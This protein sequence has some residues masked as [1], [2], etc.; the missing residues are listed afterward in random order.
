MLLHCTRV[1]FKKLN[2]LPLATESEPDWNL[3][4]AHLVRLDRRQCLFF[5]HDLTRYVV[6][7][8]GLRAEH[9]AELGK[10]HRELSLASNETSTG[11]KRRYILRLVL[12]VRIARLLEARMSEAD[13]LP[14]GKTS[15]GAGNSRGFEIPKLADQGIAN[16]TEVN[17]F[18]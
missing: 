3:W 12:G 10:W 11:R 2:S 1:L 15:H 18:A 5:C 9:F 14:H 6:F 7:L 16:R 13:S 17:L 8:A 4:H